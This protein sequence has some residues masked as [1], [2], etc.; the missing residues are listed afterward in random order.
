MQAI[1]V[2]KSY[3]GYRAGETFVA[4]AALAAVL[5]ESGVA[6]ADSQSSFLG[7]QE[8]AIYSPHNVETAVRE[9]NNV[10]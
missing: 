6:V 9:A 10:E 3:R 7:R 1:R 2:L 4:T 8:R 5:I